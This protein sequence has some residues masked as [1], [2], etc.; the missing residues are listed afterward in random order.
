MQMAAM[1]PL[2]RATPRRVV[3]DMAALLRV[4]LVLR[5][6]D[7]CR[8]G[9]TSTRPYRSSS[10]I[11]QLALCCNL[12]FGGVGLFMSLQAKKAKEAG[13]LEGARSKVK[14]AFLV[15]GIGAALE[16]VGILINVAMSFAH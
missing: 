6:E 8:V 15:M 14:T 9:Q 11:V 13:D 7:L 12:L 5:R 10:S 3:A 16:A 2:A 4:A 1:A